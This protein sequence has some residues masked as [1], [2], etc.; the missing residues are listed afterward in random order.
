MRINVSDKFNTLNYYPEQS[1]WEKSLTSLNKLWG[2]RSGFTE[3]PVLWEVA[4]VIGW[5]FPWVCQPNTS[6][7]FSNVKR[8]LI[9]VT[10]ENTGNTYLW[11][12][13]NNWHNNLATHH[14]FICSERYPCDEGTAIMLAKHPLATLRLKKN[15]AWP[16]PMTELPL[17]TLK[18]LG[19]L[20]ELDSNTALWFRFPYSM[21]TGS[22]QKQHRS[23]IMNYFICT[24]SYRCVVNGAVDC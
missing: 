11:N 10:H 3:N 23:D 22:Q 8:A 20:P 15:F 9:P 21:F 18:Q 13:R 17:A 1:V 19:L 24:V 14:N 12:N 5:L 7:T 16:C 2:L 6:L 4:L